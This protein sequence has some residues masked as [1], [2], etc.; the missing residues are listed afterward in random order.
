M[1]LAALAFIIIS[2][3]D[4]D[5]V[6]KNFDFI[7]ESDSIVPSS[8]ADSGNDSYNLYYK[9][10]GSELLALYIEKTALLN[11]AGTDT[12]TVSGGTGNSI[13]YRNYAADVQP[14]TV[15]GGFFGGGTPGI[16]EEWRGVGSVK[17]VSFEVRDANNILTGYKHEI[18]ILDVSLT[19]NNS[20]E[21]IR[22]QD[23]FYGTITTLTGFTFE[24]ESNDSGP[25][26]VGYCTNTGLLFKINGDEVLQLSF[27]D[28]AFVN[29]TSPIEYNLS[30]D[31]DD[32]DILFRVFNGSIGSGNNGGDSNYLCLTQ[33][34]SPTQTQRWEAVEGMVKIITTVD[35][36]DPTQYNHEI[37]LYNI[38]FQKTGS[39]S[40]KFS[41]NNTDGKDYYLVGVYNTFQ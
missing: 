32:T 12:I 29:A 28:A 5:M 16:L 30:N 31:T 41:P 40:E 23:T 7:S 20:D 3:D 33:P 6:V 13:T 11:K 34:A 1:F 37:R 26:T 39:T 19:K 27:P 21:E 4:G 35:T 36:A 18:T 2:C 15:C 14:S 22:M 17:I 24:F 25:I 10:E 8:C 9:K 38:V